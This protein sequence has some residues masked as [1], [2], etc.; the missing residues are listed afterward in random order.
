MTKALWGCIP[1]LPRLPRVPEARHSPV[2]FPYLNEVHTMDQGEVIQHL[3]ND[4]ILSGLRPEDFTCLEGNCRER[5][6]EDGALIVEEGTTAGSVYVI[7]EGE[8]A[9]DG[10]GEAV[11]TAVEG[12]VQGSLIGLTALSGIDRW[13]GSLRARGRVRAIEIP[14]EDMK[15]MLQDNPGASYVLMKRVATKLHKRL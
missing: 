13:G 6:F 1:R 12:D 9:R 4:D 11:A 2:I 7:V 15:Q 8:A 10:A 14:L 5:V 3:V